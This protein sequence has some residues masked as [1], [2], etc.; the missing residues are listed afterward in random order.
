VIVALVGA[1]LVA[2]GAGLWSVPAGFI[3]T[4]I[5]SIIAAYLLAYWRVRA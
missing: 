4:G 1:V 2:V 5:E 3:I